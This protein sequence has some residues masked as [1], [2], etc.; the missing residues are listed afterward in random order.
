MPIL[1]IDLK[2][3]K[4]LAAAIIGYNIS[5][6]EGLSVITGTTSVNLMS[7]MCC[8]GYSYSVIA[9][10]AQAGI[11]SVA[12]TST[13]RTQ[14]DFTSKHLLFYAISETQTLLLIKRLIKWL[15]CWN[16]AFTG[17]CF[18][19]QIQSQLL[20]MFSTTLPSL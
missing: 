10:P 16:R 9:L 18:C 8:T 1:L 7:L 4:N 2:L 6:G 17:Y 12:A 11:A 15:S 19:L 13:F 3:Y 5:Y 20:S 14:P